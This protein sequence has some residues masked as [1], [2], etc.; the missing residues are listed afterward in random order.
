MMVTMETKNFREMNKRGLCLFTALLDLLALLAEWASVRVP[1]FGTAYAKHIY[2]LLSRM[3][4]S[5]TGMLPFSLAE[6][7]LYVLCIYVLWDVLRQLHRVMHGH[8]AGFIK[9]FRHL[10]LIASMLWVLYVFLCGIN[11]NRSGFAEEELLPESASYTEEKTADG[12][13]GRAD[14]S[15]SGKISGNADEHSNENEDRSENLTALCR[16]LVQEINQQADVLK[17]SRT[18]ADAGTALFE[19]ADILGQTEDTKKPGL[20]W[21][22]RAGHAGQAAMKKLGKRYSSLAGSYPYPKPV[23][24]TRLLSIQQTT[25]IYSPFT[26]EANYNRDIPYYNIP[27]TICHELS[28]LRGY[29]QEEEANFIAVL[30]AIGADDRYFNYS[31]YVSAWVYAGNALARTDPGNFT[32]L[33]GEINEDS[34]QDMLY[35]NAYWAQFEGAPADAHEKLNDTYLKL[36]GQENGTASY[37]QVT[38]LMLSY[39]AVHGTLA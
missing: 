32:A 30:A 14:S 18:A 19:S 39:F 29:M 34:R 38:E 13:N 24:N 10:F 28:H 8:P 3:L 31:G 22:Q 12:Q 5:V 17:K 33:Y 23:F 26:V 25:G 7:L 21:L 9:L 2:P 20:H 35:N 4:G 36:N 1:G 16:Y 6:L 15:A 37:D 27:F 11:Y